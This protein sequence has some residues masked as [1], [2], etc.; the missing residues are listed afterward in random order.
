MRGDFFNRLHEEMKNNENIFFLM[1]DTGY[2]LV[3]PLFEEFPER[4]LNVGVAEQNLIGIAAGLCNL[5]YKPI[6][7]GITN[8]M[9]HRCLEQIRNDLCM[10]D[11]P[12][13]IVGTSTGLDN[14]AL[15]ATHY[16][17]DDIGCVKPFPNMH[18]YS[19]S[20]V[21]S[22]DKI[23]D[24]VINL[25]HPAYVRIT[26]KSF[27]ENVKIEKI[28]HYVI[29]NE[30][31]DI[32]IISHGRMISNSYEAA[33]ISGKVS[34]FAMDQIKPIDKNMLQTLTTEYKIIIVVEDNFNSGLYNSV[35]QFV[36]ESHTHDLDVYSISPDESYGNYV[37]DTAYLD[38]LYGLTPD[39]I[40]KFIEKITK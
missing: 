17:V 3:E 16:M 35:C 2:N 8:F 24:E 28:N 36:V 1:G 7:Y 11:Y 5:G 14:G 30:D 10:H 25:K 19:P 4:T 18:I 32:L 20:S 39:K 34:V 38:D 13:V 27:S 33:K 26:K 31:V 23:F 9:I 22:I 6:C 12:V 15:W 37:G 21:E 29:K 40:N